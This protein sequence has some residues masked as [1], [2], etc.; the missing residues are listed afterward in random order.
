MRLLQKLFSKSRSAEA[1]AYRKSAVITQLDFLLDTLENSKFDILYMEN[2]KSSLTT[3]E[4]I[5]FI[6][7]IDRIESAKKILTWMKFN[8][9]NNDKFWKRF[10]RW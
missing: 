10:L 7:Q 9:T 1:L 8:V 4:R 3:E 2:L 5:Y 6:Q